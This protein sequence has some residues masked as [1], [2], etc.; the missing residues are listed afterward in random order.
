MAGWQDASNPTKGYGQYVREDHGG[1][2]VTN[3]RVGDQVSAGTVLAVLDQPLVVPETI[4]I[5]NLLSMEGK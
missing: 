2:Y 5:S 1:G 4:L 3:A